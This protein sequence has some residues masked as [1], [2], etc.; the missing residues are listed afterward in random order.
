MPKEIRIVIVGGGSA[1]WMTAAYLSKALSRKVAITV[2]E[3]PG[4]PRVGVG[5][6]SFST[7]HLFLEFLGL[8]EED[9]MPECNATHKLAIKFVNWNRQGQ[10]FYHPFQRF[11]RVAG[12]SI[13]EWWLKLRRH[14]VPFDYSCFTIPKMCDTCRAP[15]Y[16]DGQVFDSKA[17]AYMHSGDRSKAAVLDELKIQYPYGYHFDANLFAGFME[18]CASRRGVNTLVDDVTDVR[19]DSRGFISSV[20]TRGD[21]EVEGDLFVDCTGFR[22]LLI[23]QVLK[24]PFISFEQSLLCD[25]AVA[26]RVPRDP[27]KE[28]VK[29]YTQATALTS[30]WIWQIPL[31]DRIG[32]GY[33]YSS[34]FVSAERAEWEMRE[35]LGSPAEHC[36]AFH[37]KMRIGRNRNSWVK[38]C[39]AIGLSSGFVEPLESTGI[40][41]IQHGIEQLVTH[42]HHGYEESAIIG[43]NK[44]INNCIDGVREF[45]T[46]HYAASTRADT[47]FWKATK[48]EITLPGDLGERMLVWKHR[49]PTDRTINPQ[50][51][52]F[53][54][55]SWATMLLGLGAVPANSLGV[56]DHV[57]DE[58]ANQKF[59]EINSRTQQLCSDL[60]SQYEYLVARA[61]STR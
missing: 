32:A 55:Y 10:H 5:E 52:G 13:A 47:P 40:F 36:H 51:H 9:W 7:L 37:I 42:L 1:G 33:V 16:K 6:A 18:S 48:S 31:R 46:M 61:S 58:E 30:G 54:A 41:F 45:L 60:P 44:V 57:N 12:I 28:G 25:C 53:E 17:G 59:R 34:T 21:M 15:R 3:S 38:N 22:G 35:H 20:H 19:L 56:L 50:Y 29:P 8:S 39:V 14:A 43:Y 49:L 26:M 2:V 11:E 23:N 27:E 4:I 24:E